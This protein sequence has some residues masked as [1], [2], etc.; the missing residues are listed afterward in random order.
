MYYAAL[1][2]LVFPYQAQMVRR[3]KAYLCKMPVITDEDCLHKMSLEVEPP[4]PS[5]IQPQQQQQQQQERAKQLTGQ[6][7]TASLGSSG[8]R[9]REIFIAFNRGQN[10]IIYTCA[11]VP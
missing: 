2:D 6:N 5:S 10:Y 1:I 7:S 8:V 11:V 3:V 4:P 9:K